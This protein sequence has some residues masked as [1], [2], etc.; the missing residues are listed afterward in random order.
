MSVEIGEQ[1]P[2]FELKDQHGTPVRLSS[3]QGTKNVVLV[4]YPL[5]F[6][7]VCSGEMCA[8]RDDFPEVGRDDVELLTVSVDSTWVHRIWA[9]Q[10]GFEFG[11][12]SDFWPHG[13]VAKLYGVF[14]EDRGLSVRGTF[15]IGKDG[16]VR[17]KVV[18][19]IPQARVIADYQ[20]ALAALG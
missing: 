13:G 17:W 4:F 9:E 5:A 16:V 14:N 2:D 3:F 20:K 19:P 11:L 8:M 1:A 10:E 6:S 15:I 18:N 7:G 12:L